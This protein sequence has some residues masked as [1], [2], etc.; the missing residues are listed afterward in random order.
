MNFL[1]LYHR[2][3]IRKSWWDDFWAAF[4]LLSGLM[5]CTIWL[6]IGRILT[7]SSSFSLRYFGIVGMFVAHVHSLWCS[8]ISVAATIVRL[9]GDGRARTISKC[10]TFLFGVAGLTL[11]FQK[12]FICG[13]KV[14]VL[15]RCVI[16]VWTGYLELSL[17][18]S[19]DIWLVIAPL[20]ILQN[21]NLAGDH[22]RLLIAIFSCGVFV[23]AASIARVCFILTGQSL[24]IGIMGHLQLAIS[25]I[26]CNLL[27][28]VT[29]IYRKMIKRTT[30]WRPM[31][32]PSPPPVSHT[33][34]GRV[35]GSPQGTQLRNSNPHSIGEIESLS[36][37]TLTT[38]GSSMLEPLESS[39]TQTASAGRT[40]AT[41][42]TSHC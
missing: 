22:R 14:R 12:A 9:L 24:M 20:Y 21:M 7:P 2:I 34:S 18:L 33:G 6:A 3:R 23:T 1:R 4:A 19:G 31:L 27:V 39:Q 29:Y 13:F 30:D 25:L 41:L 36:R 17:D 15:P 8:K 5:A 38:L 11:I 26:T 32:T 42:D 16:P 10:V 28:L 37:V 40:S 35:T